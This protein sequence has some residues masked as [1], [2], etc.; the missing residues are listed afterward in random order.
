MI[1][2]WVAASEVWLFFLYAW[3]KAGTEQFRTW[4]AGWFVRESRSEPAEALG[5]AVV[6]LLG[7]V[8]FGERRVK[9]RKPRFVRYVIKIG[10]Q[11]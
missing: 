8:G 3:Q 10:K 6:M 4:Q 9:F 11:I 5:L 1:D 7:N 2:L